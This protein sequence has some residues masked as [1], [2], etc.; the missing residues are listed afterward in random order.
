M[1]A[2]RERWLLTL[3]LPS[4]VP[5][6]G[7]FVARLLKHLLGTWNIRCR[8]VAESAELRRLQGI[9]EG[10]SSRPAGTPTTGGLPRDEQQMEEG[11][12]T[13]AGRA[14]QA[15]APAAPDGRRE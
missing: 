2:A 12:D 13:G 10:L 15:P 8:A 9:V 5:N 6:A 11:Q 7:R 4:R 14:V 3:E 1:A